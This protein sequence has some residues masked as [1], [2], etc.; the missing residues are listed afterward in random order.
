MST[1]VLLAGKE[2]QL[3]QA[4]ENNMELFKEA[5]ALDQINANQTVLLSLIP[6]RNHH[7]H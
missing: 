4:T 1:K 5:E 6:V 2:Y 7:D 3:D